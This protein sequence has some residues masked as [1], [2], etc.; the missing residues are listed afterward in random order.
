[1]FLRCYFLLAQ[2]VVSFLRCIFDE[3]NQYCSQCYGKKYFHAP[4]IARNPDSAF[5]NELTGGKQF[6]KGSAGQ[7]AA[8]GFT[9]VALTDLSVCG[10]VST[11]IAQIGRISRKDLRIRVFRSFRSIRVK[12]FLILVKP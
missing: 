1:V 8:Y 5:C 10:A 4:R 3:H 9:N 11:R 12:D 2:E 7:T 6:C